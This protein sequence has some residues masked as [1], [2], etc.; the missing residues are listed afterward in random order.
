LILRPA[1]DNAQ[2]MRPAIVKTFPIPDLDNCEENAVEDRDGVVRRLT[3]LRLF[4]VRYTDITW[5][6]D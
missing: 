4:V 5:S 1:S 2:F 3:L 6:H